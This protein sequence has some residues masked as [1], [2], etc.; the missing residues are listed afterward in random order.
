MNK[1]VF[2]ITGFFISALTAMQADNTIGSNNNRTI[3]PSVNNPST[4]SEELIELAGEYFEMCD[5]TRE[6]DVTE[7]I[8][9][10]ESVRKE[11]ARQKLEKRPSSISK[12][13]N[14]QKIF[15][16]SHIEAALSIIRV[17]SKYFTTQ[18]P[19]AKRVGWG[20]KFIDKINRI[21]MLYSID[22]M[23]INSELYS[24]LLFSFLEDINLHEERFGP[25]LATFPVSSEEYELRLMLADY[26]TLSTE[27]SPKLAFI[28]NIGDSIFFCHREMVSGCLKVFKQEQFNVIIDKV[29]ADLSKSAKNLIPS[30][31]LVDKE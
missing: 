10:I 25:Y 8:L 2:L 16:D 30:D 15:G 22:K 6:K 23:P 19:G 24:M 4:P 18:L 21:E 29:I 27:K 11:R 28:F 12:T 26:Q 9:L 3:T 13:L 5:Q 17:H 14:S 20:G 31:V 7:Q 1:I